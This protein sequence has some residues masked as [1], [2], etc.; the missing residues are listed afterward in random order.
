[1]TIVPEAGA[2]IEP[3]AIFEALRHAGFSPDAVTIEATGEIRRANGKAMLFL[4]GQPA[5]WI[6]IPEPAPAEGA[7]EVMV[8][9]LPRRERR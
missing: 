7:A 1:M 5:A 8:R 4:P 2:R 6:A 3:E 9:V